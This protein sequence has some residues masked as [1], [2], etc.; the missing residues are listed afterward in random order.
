MLEIISSSWYHQAGSVVGPSYI[1]EES[2][3]G[4]FSDE[5]LKNADRHREMFPIILEGA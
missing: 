3:R 5:E 4:R 1:F 2:E